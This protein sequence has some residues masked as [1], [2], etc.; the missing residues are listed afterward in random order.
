MP[1]HTVHKFAGFTVDTVRRRLLRDG[2]P[3]NTAYVAGSTTLNG[4]TVADV[5]GTSPLVGGMLIN[6]PSDPT[7]GAIPADV[8][9]SPGN[10]ATIT[11]D[12]VIDP[13]VIDGTVISNQG[14]V[15]AVDD[16]IVDQ[17]S[18]DPATPTLND[19]TR[20]IVGT[21]AELRRRGVEFLAIPDAYYDEVPERVPEVAGQLADLRE[22]GIL[23]DHDDEGYLLQIFTKPVGDRPTVFFEIIERHGST[24]F[25]AGNFKALFEAIER[26][27]ERRGNL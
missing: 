7:P 1:E 24:G 18:D 6:A 12:V 22:Q 9:P 10:V 20:D 8:P 14:F 2:I 15:S 17:P 27:Q 5:S 21:V 13:T 11:F 25:G 16:G 23:V 26:E 3:V 4:A 19:P